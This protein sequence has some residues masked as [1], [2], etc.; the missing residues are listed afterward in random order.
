VRHSARR[1]LSLR[2]SYPSREL[3]IQRFRFLPSADRVDPELRAAIAE[4]SV[5]QDPDGR[6]GFKFDPR[7]F[8]LPQRKLPPL[9][10][11]DCPTL[12]VRGAHSTLLS[13]EGARGLA[14]EIPEARLVEIPDAG[15]HVHID[16]PEAVLPLLQEFLDESA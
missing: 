5:R 14:G 4:R 3:A 10:G 11:V 2:F 6:F 1:A 15:H 16:R 12:L 8:T 7:W 13:A 9:G